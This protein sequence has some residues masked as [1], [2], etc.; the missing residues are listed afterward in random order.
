M[1]TYVKAYTDVAHRSMKHECQMYLYQNC[2]C[3][4]GDDQ[5]DDFNKEFASD[6]IRE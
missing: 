6:K 4:D 5:G 1:N 3:E 2:S